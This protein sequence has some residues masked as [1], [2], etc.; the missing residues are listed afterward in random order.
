MLITT[1]RRASSSMFARS[2]KHPIIDDQ[3]SDAI[4]TTFTMNIKHRRQFG[5]QQSIEMKCSSCYGP[6]YS[7]KLS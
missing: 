6:T 7:L 3:N 2:C 4:F 1:E 5:I